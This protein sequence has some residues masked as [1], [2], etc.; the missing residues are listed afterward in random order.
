MK[1]LR[2]FALAL[3]LSAACRAPLPAPAESVL[4][5]VL[6][7]LEKPPVAACGPDPAPARPDRMLLVTAKQCLSCRSMGLV[8][9]RLSASGG[10]G[11]AVVVPARDA[12]AVCAFARQEHVGAS[13]LAL[14][15]RVFPTGEVGERFLYGE[16]DRRGAVTRAR[17][18]ADAEELF[19]ETGD[20][21]RPATGAAPR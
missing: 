14:P 12:E 8:M 16:V 2:G 18:A 10:A 9:R 15:D 6:R 11:L 19:R 3:A 21:A 20:G 13:V 1:R 7:E 17:F 4:A 5:E